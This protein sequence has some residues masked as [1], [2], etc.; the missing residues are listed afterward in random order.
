MKQSLSVIILT[1][2]LLG[3]TNNSEKYNYIKILSISKADTITDLN[4]G[5]KLYNFLY[6]NPNTDSAIFRF[7]QSVDPDIFNTYTGQ[8]EKK[9]YADTLAMLVSLL[10]HHKNGYLPYSIDSNSTYCGPELYVEY[11][12][13][14]GKHY[15]V[16]ILDDND[17]LSILSDFFHRLEELPWEKV[18]ISNESVDETN[19][20]V[21]FLKGLGTYDSIV[22][23]Y[24]ALPCKTGVELDKLNGS[25]RTIGDKY[26]DATFNYWINKIDSAGTWTINRVTEGKTTQNYIGKIKSIKNNEIKVESENGLATLEI[27]NLTENCFEYRHKQSKQIWRLDRIK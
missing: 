12:D 25:W 1:L 11:S 7:V 18:K 15:N 27:L 9:E 10:K 2:A 17:A 23:P 24:V 13:S 5:L 6:Y 22:K 4:K 19:I 14:K 21:N 8:F 26:N 3:C 20:V 16:F